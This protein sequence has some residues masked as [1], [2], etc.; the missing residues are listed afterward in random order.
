MFKAVREEKEGSEAISVQATSGVSNLSY[1]HT[2]AHLSVLLYC[3]RLT[4]IQALSI[5]G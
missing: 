3:C 5:V 4:V 1:T 2:H